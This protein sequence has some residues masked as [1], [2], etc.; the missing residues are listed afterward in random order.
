MIV[1][2][3]KE[4]RALERVYQ[5]KTAE[6]VVLYGRRRV[7]KTYLIREFFSNKEC[8]FFQAN[9]VQKG[10]LDV[11]LSHFSDAM[12]QAF[13]HGIALKIPRSWDEAFQ[14]LNQFLVHA[15]SH[16]KIVLFL[17]ELPWLATKKSGC[18]QALDYYWNRYWS[19]DSRL[20]LVVCGSSVS[21]LIN[22]ILYNKG[23][24][25]N[26]CT[27]E[28]KLDPFLLPDVH[29]Y[30]KYKGVELNH[31]HVLALYMSLGGIPYYL[32]YVEKGLS[33]AEN[34]QH[35]LFDQHAPLKDE[36]RKLFHSLFQDAS[37]YI[38]LITLIAQKRQGVA[39]AEIE[40]V[41]GSSQ[42]GGRLTE[43]LNGLIQTNFIEAYTP[44][45][46]KRGVFYRV[47]DEFSLFYS[48]W[49]EPQKTHKPPKHYWLN[50]TTQ[51]QYH[52]W[53]GYAFEAV[54]FKHIDAILEALNIT[55]AEHITSWR[56]TGNKTDTG[57][58]IDMLIDRSD[59]AITL[60]EIKYTDRPFVINKN[61][62][63][64]LKRKLTVF[65]DNTKTKKNIF[66]VLISANGLNENDYS[67]AILS[68]TIT[69]ENL[70]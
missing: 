64:L 48:Y 52:A 45:D 32:N 36:F 20:I 61:E 39:R 11:Q 49:V 37:H 69:L 70:F 28:I 65:T 12:A 26:R 41:L 9:G 34:I 43:R 60:C 46:K 10:A 62:S 25:H 14:T 3:K 33:A 19:T 63:E 56:T 66:F 35:I 8:L 2:R 50:K 16:K 17:D 4:L 6:F 67:Q 38:E 68:K 51:P 59:D 54:C 21:W 29:Q 31:Q 15:T 5:S 1:G 44:W 58:Q 42:S 27:C 18:L 24:L 55:T 30:L 57:A 53:A 23:G 13:T 40:T 47:I 7:G 22:N